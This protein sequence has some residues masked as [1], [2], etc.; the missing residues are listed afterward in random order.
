MTETV[1]FRGPDAQSPQVMVVDDEECIRE[2]MLKLLDS[3]GIGALTVAG[4]DDCLRLLREGF[5]GVIL[6]DVMMPGKDGWETI[7]EMEKEGLMQ[8]NIISMLTAM[9]VPDERL[10]GLKETV[11]DYILKPFEPSELIVS[12]RRYLKLLDR[13]QSGA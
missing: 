13:V 7:R 12:V 1:R 5:R 4:A 10:E 2:T 6:M 3:F 11:L 8:G 9:D